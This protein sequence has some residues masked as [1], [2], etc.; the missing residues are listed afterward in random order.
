MKIALNLFDISKIGGILTVHNELKDGLRKLGHI[1]EDYWISLN[2]TR[3]PE[4]PEGFTGVL[5]FQRPEWIEAYNK[6]MSD[7]DIIIFSHPCPTEASC[8]NRKWQELYKTG[9]R[10]IVMW[11]DPIW[12]DHYPWIK[13]VFPQIDKICCIQEKAY[14][15]LIQDV[16]PKP[17]SKSLFD[18]DDEPMGVESS[19]AVHNNIQIVN[20]P[21]SLDDMGLYTERKE[22]LVLSPQYTF[23][24]WKHVDDLIRAVPMISKDIKIEISGLGTEYYYMAGSL[25]KRKDKYRNSDGTYIWDNALKHPGFKHLVDKTRQVR[26]EVLIESFKRAK[27]VVD[28]SVGE[29]GSKTGFPSMNY[30]VLEAIKY[31]CV[32]IVRKQSVI[33]RIWEESDFMIVDEPNLIGSVAKAVDTFCVYS[34][35]ENMILKAQKKLKD[36]YDNKIVARNVIK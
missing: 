12:K 4:V 8:D 31:G 25:E 16:V 10:N 34:I 7:C 14:Y 33:P 30:T 3:L 27:C 5:G 32:P 23:K 15:S 11:H 35:Q 2:T 6:K 36:H 21:L 26:R 29:R 1:V 19:G 9:K 22:N 20:H 24:S 17:K 18:F 28:L 13:E